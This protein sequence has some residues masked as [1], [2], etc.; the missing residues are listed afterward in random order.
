MFK[1]EESKKAIGIFYI[2]Q[3]SEKNVMIDMAANYWTDEISHAGVNQISYEMGDGIITV[4]DEALATFKKNFMNYISKIF[5]TEN[6]YLMLWT[7]N[8]EYFDRVGTDSYLRRIM[9]DSNLP[10]ECLPSDIT[11]WIYHDNIDVLKNYKHERIYDS[12]KVK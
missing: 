8:G 7:S 2:E 4:S 9:E 11:M 10:L 6:N 12:R 5:P 3:L 1:K